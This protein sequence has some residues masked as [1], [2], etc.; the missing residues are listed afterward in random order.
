MFRNKDIKKIFI[1]IG[2][3][4]LI[5]LC[6]SLIF[7]LFYYFTDGISYQG[8]LQLEIDF[9]DALYFSMISL[10]TIGYGDIYPIHDLSKNLVIIQGY[11]GIILSSVFSSFLVYYIL[12][13][14]SNVVFT[15][16]VL[17]SKRTD[18]AG[19][20]SHFL[21]IRIGN[22]GAYITNTQTNLDFYYEED[23]ERYLLYSTRR[24]YPV[25]EETWTFNMNMNKENKYFHRKLKK[26]YNEDK[27]LIIKFSLTGFDSINGNPIFAVKTY[28]EENIEF[29]KGFKKLKRKGKNNKKID[30]GNFNEIVDIEDDEKENFFALD[31]EEHKVEN[32]NKQDNKYKKD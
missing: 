3:Y 6:L 5:F 23:N 22:K 25:I 15:D 26:I 18:L 19:E 31:N 4:S 28:K 17:I 30:W 13:R 24:E 14:P 20:Q 16:K 10:F 9:F 2:V 11:I 1:A 8:S 12:K 29:G 7:A 32:E 21:S 27:Q